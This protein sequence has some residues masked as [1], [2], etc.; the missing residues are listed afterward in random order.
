L[1]KGKAETMD[2]VSQAQPQGNIEPK[3]ASEDASKA[4]TVDTINQAQSQANIEPDTTSEED[5]NTEL[6]RLE[7]LKRRQRSKIFYLQNQRYLFLALLI[8]MPVGL[9]I[10]LFYSEYSRYAIFS[11]FRDALG[12]QLTNI[13]E[14][15]VLYL[16]IL[17]L[18]LIMSLYV[19][20]SIRRTTLSLNNTQNTIDQKNLLSPKLRSNYL[21]KQYLL[22]SGRAGRIHWID[23]TRRKQSDKLRNLL[24]SELPELEKKDYLSD[25]ENVQLRLTMWDELL[26]EEERELEEQKQWKIMSIGIAMAYLLLLLLAIP[27][28]STNADIFGIPFPI[29]IWSAVGSFAAILYRFYK[30]PRRVKFEVEFRWLVARPIIG[31]VMGT[32]AYLTL[33][34]GMMIFGSGNSSGTPSTIE[35]TGQMTQYWIVA[36]LA[37]FS[38]KFYEKIIELLV[39]RFGTGKEYEEQEENAQSEEN[40][41]TASEVTT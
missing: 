15:I 4:E 30:S 28:F 6:E 18:F 26:K 34:S 39:S 21:Q 11:F 10:A 35:E 7:E 24:G 13:Q 3:L 5:T 31:I 29:V 32:L 25:W 2:T 9:T 27:L 33:V 12:F 22:Q 17:I 8:F 36:F 37:G 1:L 19:E 40:P 20:A 23:L 14:F 38:D 16:V 41:P